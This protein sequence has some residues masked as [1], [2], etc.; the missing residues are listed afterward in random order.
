V[1]VAKALIQALQVFLNLEE[2]LQQHYTRTMEMSINSGSMGPNTL[3][4]SK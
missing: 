2:K 1:V 4:N 3:I